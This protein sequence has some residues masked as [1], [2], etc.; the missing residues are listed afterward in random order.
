M[1]LQ[2]QALQSE[3]SLRISTCSKI[4]YMRM[5]MECVYI[6]YSLISRPPQFLPSISVHSNTQEWRIVFCH[7]S[8]PV[9]CCEHKRDDIIPVVEQC[10]GEIKFTSLQKVDWRVGTVC[11]ILLCR[12][13][14]ISH[15]GSNSQV[16]TCKVI[17]IFS[18]K[19]HVLHLHQLHN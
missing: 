9:Y 16:G 13:G 14:I 19:H 18:I 11:S 10:C 8:A 17:T 6:M 12:C 4:V 2:L 7:P 1:W 15:T 5:S 3:S